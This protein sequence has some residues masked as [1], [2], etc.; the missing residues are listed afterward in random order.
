MPRLGDV[1][2][3][4]VQVPAMSEQRAALVTGAG[5]GIG[6]ARSSSESSHEGSTYSR[7][8]E[9]ERT[10]MAPALPHAPTSPSAEGNRRRH[11]SEPRC[12]RFGRMTP[13]PVANAGLQPPSRRLDGQRRDRWVG[14][15]AG[16]DAK[17][18]FLLATSTDGRPGLERRNGRRSLVANRRQRSA[19]SPRPT[20]RRTCRPSTACWDGQDA[21]LEGRADRRSRR[22]PGT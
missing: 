20:R 21:A 17:S 14:P 11:R 12:E 19:G 6:L 15:A 16:R 3:V 13:G 18:T 9:L 4:K 7:F 8:L 5:G 22:V 10:P 2:T 1:I